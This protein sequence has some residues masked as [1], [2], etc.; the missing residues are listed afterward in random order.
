[1]DIPNVIG[2]FG[3]NETDSRATTEHL[4]DVVV[5]LVI[6]GEGEVKISVFKSTD[7]GSRGGFVLRIT[8]DKQ[9]SGF[10]PFAINLDDGIEVHI[11]GE[12]EAKQTSTAL[13]AAITV[14]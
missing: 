6:N 7:S 2:R 10:Q 4:C 11:A 5:P 12:I 1:M 8:M 3:N 13:R 9:D 14:L